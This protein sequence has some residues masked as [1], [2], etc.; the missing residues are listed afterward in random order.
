MMVL[1]KNLKKVFNINLIT[2][3]DQS[4]DQLV[5]KKMVFIMNN[6]HQ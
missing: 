1:K 2:E 3:S 4:V 6:C 5:D